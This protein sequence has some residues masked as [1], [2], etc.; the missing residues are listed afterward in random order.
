MQ[1]GSMR[2]LVVDDEALVRDNLEAYLQDEN[3]V[4]HTAG[5]GEE[6]LANLPQSQPDVAVVDMRLPGISGEEFISQAH[7]LAPQLKFI[8]HTGSTTYRLSHEMMD[9]GLTR[10]E[11]FI[12][13]VMDMGDLVR[14]MLRLAESSN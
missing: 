10:G 9:I 7:A 2:V 4:V 6:A 14:V 11:V 1:S 8:I 3:F 13:P 5:S 12:K